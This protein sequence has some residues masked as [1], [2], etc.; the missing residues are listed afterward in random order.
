MGKE[1]TRNSCCWVFTLSFF[2]LG[3]FT[4]LL[5]KGKRDNSWFNKD[6]KA[7]GSIFSLSYPNY[8]SLWGKG[9]TLSVDYRENLHL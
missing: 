5:S 4:V 3:L 7:R 2:L 1:H 9:L 8:H 6:L